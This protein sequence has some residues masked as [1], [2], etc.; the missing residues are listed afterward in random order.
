MAD[1]QWRC[2]TPGIGAATL[3]AQRSKRRPSGPSR[4]ERARRSREK[5][6]GPFSLIRWATLYW[7][8]GLLIDTRH[9]LHLS[10][11]VLPPLSAAR[12]R[13]LGCRR[14]H[15]WLG[16]REGWGGAVARGFSAPA[17][18]EAAAP[19]WHAIVGGAPPPRKHDSQG[20][21]DESRRENLRL[22][23]HRRNS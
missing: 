14:S 22:T 4:P 16:K 17:I 13:R 15:R 8:L 7:D 5:L 23:S 2:Q 18:V 11:P 1:E 3:A 6:N 9:S 12:Q 21:R 10:G 19:R 20:R